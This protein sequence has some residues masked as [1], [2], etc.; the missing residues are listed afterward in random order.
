[1]LV[2]DFTPR[3][4][5]EAFNANITIAPQKTALV[6]VDFQNLLALESRNVNHVAEE[7]TLK[8]A[9][10]AV[11]KAGIQVVWLNWG[12]TEEDLAALNPTTERI[13]KFQ[14]NGRPQLDKGFGHEMGDVELANGEVVHAGRFLM[15]DQWNSRLHGP[16]GAAYQESLETS[17]PDKIFH[18]N[19]ISGMCETKTECADFLRGAGF[20]TLLFAGCNTDVCVSATLQ[21]ASLKD[22]DCIL[23][24]DGTGTTNG[25]R[26]QWTTERNC[27]KGWGFVSWC[28]A[29]ETGVSKMR[30]E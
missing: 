11:R 7:V 21:D 2:H 19:R 16:S 6:I 4:E 8:H 3:I 18:K 5:L 23:L 10:P 20:R 29:L 28:T 24:A 1:M 13:H 22:F 27:R 25:D 17:L 12:L 9:I 26:A 15:Q 14:P 30:L